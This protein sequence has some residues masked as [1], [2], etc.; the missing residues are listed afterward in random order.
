MASRKDQ[1]VP[2]IKAKNKNIIAASGDISGIITRSKARDL[3]AAASAPA[4]TLSKEQEHL[5]Y[6]PVITLASL[7]ASKGESPRKYSESLL[8][9]ADSSGSTT[10]QVMTTGATS[11]EEQLAQMNEAIAKL[12][13]TVEE[14]DLQIAALVNQLDAQPDVKVDPIQLQEMIASTIKTQYEGSSH[15]SVLYSKPYSKKID[16]L[17]MP[18][19]YQPPKFMQFDGKGNPKQHVAHFIETCNNAGT[20]GDY[21]VKQFVR[22]LKS[23]KPRTFEELA[24][25]AHDM[26]LSINR[27]GKKEQ[28]ADYKDDK[29]LGPKVDKATWKPTKEAMTVNTTPVKIPTRSKAIQTEAFRDQEIRRRTLKELEEKTYPFPDSDVV[30]MLKDLLDKKVIDLPECKRPE[31]MNRTNSPSN[32]FSNPSKDSKYKILNPQISRKLPLKD[33]AVP[34][35]KA[36]NKNII[37]ASGDISGI[38]TR[39]KARDLFAAAS[40]P[41]L[42]LSKEQEHLRYEPVITLASLRASRGESPRKYSESLLSDA[43]SSGSTTMQ[44][45]TTGATSIEEQLAQM[46]EAIAKLT[47]TV[48]EKDL[49]IAALVNQLDALPD[50]KVDPIVGLLKK[51]GDEEDEPPVEKVEEKP[52]LDQATT[53]MGSLSIQQLQ[54]MIAS[55]IKTQYEGSSHD[56]VLYSKPYSKKIDA[57]KMLRGY[58]PPKFMQFDGKGNPKQHVAHFIETCNNAGTEGDYL[59]KQFVRSLKSIKPRTFEELATRAH[60]MELSINR[61][62]KKEQIADYK[63]DKVLGPKVDKATWKPTKEAMTVNTT[64][65]KI[66]TRSKAI[67]TEAFRDQEI[68]RRTLKEL[69]EKTYPFPDSDVVAMLKDLLDKKVIDLPECKRPEDMNCTDNPRYCKF[70]RFISHPTEK[71]FML[72]DLIMKLAQKGIIELDLNDVVKSNYTTVTSGSLNS[73]SSPQPLGACSKTMSVKSSEVEGWTYVTPKKMHKKHRPPPQVRQSERGQSSYRQPS[74]LHESIEDDEVMTQR[75]S[76]AI[77]MRDFFPK[78]FFNHSVKTPC[79]ED[80]KECL[81]QIA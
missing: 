71:C 48:E 50:V 45:M 19:G 41:A 8:S 25:R 11:I 28:I 4:L 80:C 5:R 68:R 24:T 26:E 58:Q 21:L 49:Q 13:R 64:P 51:E 55:T 62:G 42:T 69:E 34:A 52:K 39:S 56:S 14:K 17:K 44:V 16:A 7:R 10:M 73:K 70:H 1:A 27:H 40:A 32:M 81:S 57:L 35:I 20:E 67:Q 22:S 78:D 3:F 75:S 77:T 23:I 36:K 53:S 46:N 72:K 60:D 61:H 63:N 31:D 6:E 66:P 33:Q 18:R 30:A 37:A 12:T 47:R 54:E 59:V 43:D 15:D 74:K 29:V 79:Y 2:A 76:V 9:D 38:I 65:V